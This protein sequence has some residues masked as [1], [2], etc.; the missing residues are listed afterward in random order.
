MYLLSDKAGNPISL[1]SPTATL[2]IGSVGEIKVSFQN[3]AVRKI[4]ELETEA[5]SSLDLTQ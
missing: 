4:L 5:L 2:D 1:T 3:P